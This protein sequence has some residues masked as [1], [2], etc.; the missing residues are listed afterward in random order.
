MNN[1]T[2]HSGD[3]HDF[4]EFN[5]WSYEDEMLYMSLTEH[6]KKV[7]DRI[8]LEQLTMFLPDERMSLYTIVSMVRPTHIM[9]H[10]EIKRLII[11]IYGNG[12]N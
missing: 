2:P 12:A 9:E 8:I 1:Y 5:G 6:E 10:D 11:E 7:V 3:S 4:N